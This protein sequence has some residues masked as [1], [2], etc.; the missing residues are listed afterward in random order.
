MSI[1]VES[2]VEFAKAAMQCVGEN[3]EILTELADDR[4]A[5]HSAIDSTVQ[6][7][8]SVGI[9]DPNQFDRWRRELTTHKQAMAV[10]NQLVDEL[11]STSGKEAS[12]DLGAPAQD[13]YASDREA[14]AEN[15]RRQ[16]ARQWR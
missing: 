7:M 9:I 5:A 16:L 6:K 14:I 13:K 3:H 15:R 11:S 1:K 12:D 4:Q 2:V 8:A 10:I